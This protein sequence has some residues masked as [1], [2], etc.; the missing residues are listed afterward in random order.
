MSEIYQFKEKDYKEKW[1]KKFQ[2]DIENRRRMEAIEVS[3]NL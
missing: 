3:S 1:M 2:E